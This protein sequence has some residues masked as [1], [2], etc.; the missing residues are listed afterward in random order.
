MSNATTK[1]AK[2]MPGGLSQKSRSNP[3]R[4][5]ESRDE[6]AFDMLAVEFLLW[7]GVS[8]LF[9]H[10]PILDSGNFNGFNN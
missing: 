5:D 4:D 2:L 10:T 3:Q 9:A 8:V 6:D 7:R 1:I